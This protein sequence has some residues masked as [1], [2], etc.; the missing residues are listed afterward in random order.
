MDPQNT[1]EISI[2]ELY[3][4]VI[5][6]SKE[7]LKK[8]WIIALFS[9][10][11]LLYVAYSYINHVPEYKAELRFMVESPNG[12]S[13]VGGLLG[14][15]GFGGGPGY[16]AFKIIEVSKS[17]RI[18]DQV[19]FQR[20]SEGDLLANKL[21]EVQNLKDTWSKNNPDYKEFKFPHDSVDSYSDLQKRAYLSLYKNVVGDKGIQPMINPI[22]DAETGI[23]KFSANTQSEE[24]TLM[25]VNG[26][27]EKTSYF[28][29]NRVFEEQQNTRDLLKARLDSIKTSMES[30]GLELA[31][32]SDN[33]RN[34]ITQESEYK[35]NKLQ[36]EIQT[37]TSAYTELLKNYE[38]AEYK[39]QSTKPFYLTIDQPFAPISPSTFP[40]FKKLIFGLIISV[41]LGIFFI[42]ARHFFLESLK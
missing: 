26:L 37:L 25:L 17:A 4:L 8:W 12:E 35:K 13:G 6:Y 39:L 15:L 42:I 38:L 16:N 31:R 21:L 40:L 32:F 1:R 28:F 18:I 19:I 30:K 41:F 34:L 5:E 2:K 7:V 20:T 36:L 22:Y 29:Q 11:A 27:Y 14:N 10:L 3:N 24:A 9:L 23:F 33:N